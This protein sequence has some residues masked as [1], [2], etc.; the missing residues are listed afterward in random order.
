MNMTFEELCERLMQQDEVSLLEI[1][2][3]SSE[4]IVERFKDLIELRENELK[5]ELS[6][7]DYE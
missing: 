2:D 4:D 1:L 3:I 7:E 6:D 5:D